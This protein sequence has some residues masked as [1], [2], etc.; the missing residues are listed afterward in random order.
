MLGLAWV[1]SLFAYWR[2]GAASGFDGATASNLN[3]RDPTRRAQ[4]LVLPLV[5]LAQFGSL[6]GVVAQVQKHL[7]PLA[8]ALAGK[9]TR[10]ACDAR[11]VGEEPSAR[12]FARTAAKADV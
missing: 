4:Q 11:A 2:G 1:D 5:P 8:E 10:T 6:D 12:R 7:G 9:V 3:H